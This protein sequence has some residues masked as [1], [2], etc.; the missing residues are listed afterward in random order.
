MKQEG[1][2]MNRDKYTLS[3]DEK[4]E[5][6]NIAIHEGFDK[7]FHR[8]ME[9]A[10]ETNTPL[11]YSYEYSKEKLEEYYHCDIVD[12][13]KRFYLDISEI[14]YIKDEKYDEIYTK[15]KE[16]WKDKLPLPIVEAMLQFDFYDLRENCEKIGRTCELYDL[17]EEAL[18]AIL[19]AYKSSVEEGDSTYF[20]YNFFYAIPIKE[21]G[22]VDFI[23]L[24]YTLE[25]SYNDY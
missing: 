1:E 23:K 24:L 9:I 6:T 5:L 7:A 14:H 19:C 10:V 11:E 3:L 4:K 16:Y 25:E 8:L 21:N 18:L 20:F 2:K 12:L 13:A 22:K 17:I 15:K